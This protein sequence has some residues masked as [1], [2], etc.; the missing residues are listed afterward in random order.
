MML[1][2]MLA[3]AR[4]S[5]GNFQAW[6][7]ATDP[8]L[9]AKVAETAAREQLGAA[10]WVRSAVADFTAHA[11]EEDWATLISAIRDGE[12]PGTVCLLA[13][14][15]WRLDVPDCGC[16]ASQRMAERRVG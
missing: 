8:E 6:L 13:M 16:H 5:S 7:A 9:A 1:G 11:D 15:S 14:V 10:S 12:D 2:D 4:A 3:A